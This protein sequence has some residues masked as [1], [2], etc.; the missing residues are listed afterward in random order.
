MY[1][2]TDRKFKRTFLMLRWGVMSDLAQWQYGC[3]SYR[4]EFG[5]TD[6]SQIDKL[7]LY[8]RSAWST[9]KVSIDTV[10]D[11]LRR[12]HHFK[13]HLNP[14]ISRN[15]VRLPGIP[16]RGSWLPPADPSACSSLTPSRLTFQLEHAPWCQGSK[17]TQICDCQPC[18]IT[19]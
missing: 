7:Y 14:K 3:T 11:L 13:T 19:F 8:V 10:E 4:S 15:N 18:A 1:T 9:H 6:R 17:L 2:P 5:H 16:A 12:W